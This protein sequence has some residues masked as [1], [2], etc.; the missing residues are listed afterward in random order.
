MKTTSLIKLIA[1]DIVHIGIDDSLNMNYILG[2]NEYINDFDNESK[3]Y[4]KNH[5]NQIINEIRN[6]EYIADVDFNQDENTIDMVF[7]INSV[8]DRIEKVI[9][10]I[11]LKNGHE[12]DVEKLHSLSAELINNLNFVNIIEKETNIKFSVGK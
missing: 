2:L 8:T 10:N 12:L 9:Y 5:L 4:I 11:G 1:N 3:E 7:Y 6:N